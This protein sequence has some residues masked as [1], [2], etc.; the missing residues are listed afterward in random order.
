MS[1]LPRDEC[2][3]GEGTGS[4]ASELPEFVAAGG[5]AGGYRIAPVAAVLPGGRASLAHDVLVLDRRALAGR[6][7]DR[8]APGIAVHPVELHRL[9]HVPVAE[10]GDVA[11][12]VNVLPRRGHLVVHREVHTDRLGG[13]A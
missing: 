12:D 2:A 6:E 4:E 9:G 10:L 7:E 8:A 3:M 5:A 11:G 13:G 1:P